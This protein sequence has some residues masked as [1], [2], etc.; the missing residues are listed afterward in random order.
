MNFKHR[1]DLRWRNAPW[2]SSI[3]PTWTLRV[4]PEDELTFSMLD[5]NRIEDMMFE[6][7]HGAENVFAMNLS[8][9]F[10]DRS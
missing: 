7:N 6:A 10:R 4:G 3:M 8:G 1:F 9:L 5:V 2:P